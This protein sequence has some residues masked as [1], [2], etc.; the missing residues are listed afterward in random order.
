MGIEHKTTRS[1]NDPEAYKVC[2]SFMKHIKK[3]WHTSI[4]GNK[5][6]KFKQKKHPRAFR[7]TQNPTTGAAPGTVLYGANVRTK[8][9]NLRSNRMDHRQ[10]IKD[11][12]KRDAK[13]KDI[14]KKYKDK[15]RYMKPHEIQVGDKV[16]KEQKATKAQTHNTTPS[17]KSRAPKSR[18]YGDL[19]NSAALQR[20]GRR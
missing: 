2:K 15:G 11:A 8:M 20:S 17:P 7:A 19:K 9:P 10:D 5:D 16:L 14:M 12:R 4:A 13:Q 3:V 18:W 1:A 6:P